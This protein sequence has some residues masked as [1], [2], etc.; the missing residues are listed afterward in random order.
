MISKVIVEKLRFEVTKPYHAM[1][2]FDYKPVKC[3]WMIK[4]MVVTLAQ[5]APKSIM[6]NVI[7]ADARAKYGK[8]FS[9]ASI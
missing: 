6:K 9:R 4:Y 3:T 7:V 5:L 1:Y 2:R 8:L